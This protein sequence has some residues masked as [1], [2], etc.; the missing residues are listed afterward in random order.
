MTAA[1]RGAPAL[2]PGLSFP[3]PG[4]TL[5]ILLLSLLASLDLG[6]ASMLGRRASQWSG[7]LTGAATVVAAGR[8]LES[9]DAAAARAAEIL[10]RLP[11]VAEA[12]VLDPAPGD[13]LAGRLLGLAPGPPTT[14]PPRLVSVRSKP[15][16]ILAVDRVAAVLRDQGVTAAVDDHGAWS[17]PLERLGLLA[18][19]ALGA[20][21]LLLLAL[22]VA[23]IGALV[24]RAAADRRDRL[25]LL[26]QLG[27]GEASLTR[28][29]GARA[30]A[31]AAAGAALGSGAVMAIGAILAFAPEAALRLPIPASAQIGRAHD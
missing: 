6:G 3:A 17:G 2:L 22:L 26:V 28:P 14:A 10:G 25:G 31:S 11:A 5:A 20:L 1:A 23:V 29:F 30:V 24:G 18:A 27:A 13:A 19:V 16:A 4:L 7:R 12:R 15:G 21:F 9:A 8:D